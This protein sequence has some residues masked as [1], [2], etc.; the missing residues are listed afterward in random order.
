VAVRFAWDELAMPNLD[1]AAGLPALPFR[2]DNWPLVLEV[3]KVVTPP[4]VPK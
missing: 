1:N 2:T 4:P 3:P